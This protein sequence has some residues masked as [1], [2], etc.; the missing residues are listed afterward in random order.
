MR[1]PAQRVLSTAFAPATI[2]A[3]QPTSVVQ[4]GAIPKV[5]AAITEAA[6]S[7]VSDSLMVATAEGA[8]AVAPD[9]IQWIPAVA[10][11]W[12]NVR[13]DASRGGDVVGV[14]KPSEKAMLGIGRDGWRQVKSPDISGWV[15]PK[16]F[17]SDS[18]HTR[19]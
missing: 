9:S 4:V 5:P 19:G 8:L 18:L 6:T 14:I 3:A 2:S 11:T 17:E 7:V 10:R 13:A 15:D 16:L 12:V 1:E